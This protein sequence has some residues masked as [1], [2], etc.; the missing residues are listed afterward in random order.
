[1]ITQVLVVACPCGIGLAAP[2]ATAVGL[3]LAAQAG[4][5]AQGGGSAFQAATK[6]DTVVFDKC[7]L[8]QALLPHLA[9]AD[10]CCLALLPFPGP[11][12]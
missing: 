9:G 11:A 3:G 7:G 12:P 1:L 2:T 4:V 10:L 5:L 8:A 6:V